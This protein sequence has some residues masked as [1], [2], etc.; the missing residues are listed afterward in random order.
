MM[1]DMLS[2]DGGYCI[3]Q[4]TVGNSLYYGRTYAITTELKKIAPKMVCLDKK[5]TNLEADKTTSLVNEWISKY[6]NE[7]KGIVIGDAGD[8]L[9]GTMD[10][11]RKSGRKDIVS[12]TTGNCKLSLDCIEEG[13]L[14]GI[15]WQSAESDGALTVEIAIDWFNG[16]EIVPIKYLPNFIITRDTYK[17][18]Y[19]PQW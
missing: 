18:Y 12:V 1:A 2:N 3:V 7:L 19:P 13:L 4:H 16:L 17:N 10:A 6:G 15:A 9:V 11:L 5:S 8:P 14:H